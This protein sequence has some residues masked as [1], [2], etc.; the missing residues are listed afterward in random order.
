MRAL[1]ARHYLENSEGQRRWQPEH[2]AGFKAFSRPQCETGSTHVEQR[3]KCCYSL[4]HGSTRTYRKL[5]VLHFHVC[6]RYHFDFSMHW[7]YVR[8]LRSRRF[9]EAKVTQ[10]FNL[11]WSNQRKAI[12]FRKTYFDHTRGC[13]MC[14][15]PCRNITLCSTYRLT[16]WF[17]D[18]LNGWLIKW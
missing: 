17:T 16:D 9:A 2:R 15:T 14:C 3:R 13:S 7:A 10:L 12:N 4:L 8:M 5:M 1:Q 6:E 18:C 11:A